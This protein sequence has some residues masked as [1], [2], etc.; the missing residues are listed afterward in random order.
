M[1]GEQ[2]QTVQKPHAKG[3]KVGQK[4]GKTIQIWQPKESSNLN[5][6]QEKMQQIPTNT[7]LQG[8]NKSTTPSNDTP[9]SSLVKDIV[10]SLKSP[11]IQNVVIPM[12]EIPESPAA[13]S[14]Q[15]DSTS[16]KDAQFAD[17]ETIMKTM[18]VKILIG[19]QMRMEKGIMLTETLIQMK[20]M[21]QNS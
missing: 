20:C 15:P 12:P 13:K 11:P 14:P 8:L 2:T 3:G 21:L 10:P 6:S 17:F 4:F 16:G 7:Q 9:E 1:D 19:A 5:T 18:L